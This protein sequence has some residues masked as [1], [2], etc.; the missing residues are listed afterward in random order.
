MTIPQPVVALGEIIARIATA[1]RAAKRVA[2]STQLI[3]VSKTYG[4]PDIEPVL[5]AGHRVFGENRVQ[6]AMQ[7]WPDL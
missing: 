6:E 5:D 2:G 1:E 7:K 4:A 3:A